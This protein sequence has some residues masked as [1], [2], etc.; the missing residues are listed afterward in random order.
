M[1]RLSR[2]RNT[3]SPFTIRSNRF[4]IE[5]LKFENSI[6]QELKFELDY[7]IRV[8]RRIKTL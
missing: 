8:I 5:E 7:L 3:D 2:F 4:G 1:I 6:I